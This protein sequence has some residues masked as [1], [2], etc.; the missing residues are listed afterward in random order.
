[1]AKIL[2]INVFYQGHVNPT[3]AVVKELIAAG[4]EVAYIVSYNFKEAIKATGAKFIPYNDEP[5]THHKIQAYQYAYNTALQI[6]KDYDLIMYEGFFFTGRVL[7]QQLNKP[8]VRLFSTFALNRNVFNLLLQGGD[9]FFKVCNNKWLRRIYVERNV[10]VKSL[11]KEHKVDDLLEE[12]LDREPL[13]N[14]TFTS[15]RFQVLNEEFDE[16]HYKFIGPSITE[17]KSTV[18]I[19]FEKMKKPIVYISLGTIY[20]RSKKFFK[21]CIEALKDQDITVIMSI[22]THV[23]KEEI[24]DI[25]SNFFIYTFVPQLE[26][27]KYASLFIS[28]SG[29]NSINEAIYFGVPIISVPMASDQ[30]LIATRVAELG[31]GEVIFRKDISAERIKSAVD[32]VLNDERY[33]T[34]I[35]SMQEDMLKLG[36]AK[37]AVIE[38]NNFLDSIKVKKQIV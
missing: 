21:C 28:H 15:R 8:A 6:G 13:L 18:D 22:G 27:L 20:N 19:P 31:L 10:L 12:V 23:K 38:I 1:M 33:R 11:R 5:K 7:A 34:N 29:M 35:H 32:K 25:P 3:L 36:G 2:M 14:I 26:V 37:Q 17:R 16:A 24:G 9:L 30:P 4:H